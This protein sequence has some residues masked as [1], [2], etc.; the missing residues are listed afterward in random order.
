MPAAANTL[1]VGSSGGYNRFPFGYDASQPTNY[2][3]GA[4]YQQLFSAQDFASSP[5]LI[6]AVSFASSSNLSDAVL[7]SYSLDVH[8]GV[9][10]TS[11]SSPS[12][13]FAAN[14]GPRYQDVFSGPYT[15]APQRNDVF[16]LILTLSSPFLYDPAS[17]DL[18]LDVRLTGPSVI[19]GNALYFDGD[20]SDTDSRV[21]NA[22][23][24]ASTGSTNAFTLYTEF[25]Y[26]PQSSG[27]GSPVPEPATAA[28][29]ATAVG[30][31]FI[32]RKWRRS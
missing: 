15:F 14:R 29:L 11:A 31:L 2:Q 7:A 24:S 22:A 6:S 13:T 17:G 32:F 21:F 28:T 16:D 18:L 8:L 25:T 4:D 20:L 10:A 27:S 26:T 3:S 1:D 9:A 5:I 30:A 23:S 19:T 12:T